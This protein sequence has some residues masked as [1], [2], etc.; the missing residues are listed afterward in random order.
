M[1]YNVIDLINK[2]INIAI[3]KKDIYESIG[4]IKCDIPFIETMSKVLAKEISNSINYYEELKSAVSESNTEEIDFY[5]YD[6]MSF[7][8]D[9]FNKKICATDINNIKEYLKFS[10]NLERDAKSLLMDIQGRFLRDASDIN[11]KTYKTL[12]DMIINKE[13]LVTSL[14]KIVK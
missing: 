2:S 6:K 3:R 12:S 10:L 1:G 8:I 13:K 9:E 7:L 4:Q 5:I 14:E 11:T